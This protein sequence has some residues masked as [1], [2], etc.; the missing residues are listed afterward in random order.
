MKIEFHK[1]FIKQFSKLNKKEKKRILDTLK[2]FEVNPYLEQLKN[3]QLKGDMAKLRSINV[4]GDIRLHYYEKEKN[5]VIVIFVA[6]GT[7][8]QLY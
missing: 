7:H 5:H 1:N 3:H 4:G 8:S 6:I 2:L